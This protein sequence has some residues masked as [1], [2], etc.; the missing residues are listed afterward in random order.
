MAEVTVFDGL[1]LGWT[2]TS[3][4]AVDITH[5]LAV[6]SGTTEGAKKASSATSLKVDSIGKITLG[7]DAAG[8][9]DQTYYALSAEPD[10][11]IT[12][13]AR[14]WLVPTT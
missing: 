7:N 8:A 2:Y 4:L 5:D 10:E 13:P 12:N 14:G 6:V 9:N 3:S 1:D 11:T